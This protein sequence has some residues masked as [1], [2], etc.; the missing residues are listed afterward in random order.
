MTQTTTDNV[1]RI[2]VSC[3]DDVLAGTSQELLDLRA[4]VR[5]VHAAED[6][7]YA[8]A[9]DDEVSREHKRF[10]SLAISEARSALRAEMASIDGGAS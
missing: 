5:R 9:S 3:Q 10:L 1:L 7:Y 2:W 6:R 8:Q 4:A